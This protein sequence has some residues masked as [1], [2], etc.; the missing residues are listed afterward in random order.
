V[1]NKHRKTL[2][3]IFHR[4][5]VTSLRFS[6][7]EAVVIALGGSVD[8]REDSRVRF[9]LNEEVWR[10]HRPHP[11]KDAKRYQAEEASEFL[12]SAGVRP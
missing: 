12:T 4:P 8:E 7:I 3:L 6:D 1:N 10:C 9:E 2:E 5:T 11:G